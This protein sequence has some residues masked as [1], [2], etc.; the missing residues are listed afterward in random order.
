MPDVRSRQELPSDMST[1]NGSKVPLLAIPPSL[2]EV[3]GE[4]KWSF[5]GRER[6]T[7]AECRIVGRSGRRLAT[8]QPLRSW[9]NDAFEEH[10]GH[11]FQGDHVL[12][13]TTSFRARP[14]QMLSPVAFN[15]W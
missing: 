3:S 14:S 10:L 2:V 13:A 9:H 6:E 12:V 15:L 1:T 5:E 4:H 11:T 7:T 8:K